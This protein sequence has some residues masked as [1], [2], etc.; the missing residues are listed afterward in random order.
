MDSAACVIQILLLFSL[1]K[2]LALVDTGSTFNLISHDFATLHVPGFKD[3]FEKHHGMPSLTL[4]DGTLMST[5]GWIDNIQISMTNRKGKIVHTH[6]NFLVV[7]ALPEKIVIG[8]Q[9]FLDSFQK[10]GRQAEISYSKKSILLGR[11]RIPW[12][13]ELPD[14]PG[15]S[16]N[17]MTCNTYC[18][19]PPH[20]TQRVPSTYVNT[21]G[22]TAA[23][24]FFSNIIPPGTEMEVIESFGNLSQLDQIDLWVTNT[25]PFTSAIQPGQQL[26][27]FDE[28]ES[29]DFGIYTPKESQYNTTLPKDT[30]VNPT[31]TPL[32]VPYFHNAT[33]IHQEGDP[34]YPRKMSDREA[35]AP[36][37]AYND[38]NS[39]IVP[40]NV[41]KRQSSLGNKE[42][43]D[44]SQDFLDLPLELPPVLNASSHRKD[45]CGPR[46]DRGERETTLAHSEYG[47][48]N[49]GM[50][51]SCN[52]KDFISTNSLSA[53]VRAE[54]DA[55]PDP[56]QCVN[57]K[58]YFENDTLQD[59][60]LPPHLKG[61]RINLDDTHLTQDQINLLIHYCCVLPE[62][63]EQL[64]SPDNEPGLVKDF[65]VLVDIDDKTGWQARLTPCSPADREEVHK[66]I[67]EYL[68]KGIIEPCHGPYASSVLFVR[69]HS[70]RHKIACCL[71]TLNSRTRKNS[72]PVPLI[73]DNLDCLANRLYLTAIDVCGGYLSM[74]LDEEDRDYFGFI[75]HFGLYRWR[76][77]PYGWRNSGSNFCYLMDQITAGLKY[78]ILITYV[79][80][81]ILYHGDT[82]EEH[83]RALNVT[84]NR[85]QKRGLRLSI[86]KCSFCI[87]KFEYLGVIVSRQGLQPSPRNVDKIIKCKCESVSDLRSFVGIAQFYR[88]WIK[89]FAQIVK[90]LY[91]AI[92]DK[93]TSVNI[94]GNT[95]L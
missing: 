81:S 42:S 23:W 73:R 43:L 27:I 93:A 64:F 16:R 72:Y 32:T 90:V 57:I 47:V 63:R 45:R 54:L 91:D 62:G 92:K 44:N 52:V 89:N 30:S 41:T 33:L 9:Y 68:A 79:D 82:F 77:V 76:R 10:T 31:D 88:R 71:N 4:G 78:Q 69:K 66:L 35:L 85:F 50:D 61:F 40:A 87:K 21:T 18:R 95:K 37:P 67:E 24:G 36:L 56:S 75:T 7:Q 51:Q 49:I 8:H 22:S 15:H 83:L 80:D 34:V 84:F 25:S 12:T 17:Y 70:G 11:H 13:Y 29:T 6:A 1:T 46:K 65:K 53:S 19:I 94:L 74:L 38:S 2:V 3:K 48:T 58:N 26:A 20:T 60:L 28:Y 55:E 86:V 14:A 39:I 59:H 5:Q